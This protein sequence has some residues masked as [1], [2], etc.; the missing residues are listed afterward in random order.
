MLPDDE[1]D[2]EEVVGLASPLLPPDEEPLKPDV[3]PPV[4][5]V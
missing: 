4:P 1:V 5:V 2:E 3:A